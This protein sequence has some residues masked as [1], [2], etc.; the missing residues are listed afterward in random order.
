MMQKPESHTHTDTFIPSPVGRFWL[1]P[2][3]RRHVPVRN[4]V[5]VCRFDRTTAQ[6]PVLEV[7]VHPPQS[8]P[9]ARSALAKLWPVAV[10]AIFVGWTAHD[11]LPRRAAEVPEDAS[12]AVGVGPAATPG[13][14]GIGVVQAPD[15]ATQ[16]IDAQ[17]PSLPPSADPA[18]IVRD[19][20][21]RQA[22]ASVSRGGGDQYEPRA[23]DEEAARRQQET[24][25][26]ARA[27]RLIGLLRTA[28][29]GYRLQVCS[30]A[31]GGIAVSTTRDHTGPYISARAEA[32]ALEEGARLAGVS[33]G[34]VRIPWGEFPEPEDP[35]NG[36]HPAAVAE[37]WG[38]GN[39]TGWGH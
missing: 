2:E 22:T 31:R 13:H 30:E 23:R 35:A 37:R 14:G 21:P 8:P 26:R 17:R 20:A 6:V 9:P 5:C 7:G 36:Y 24:E 27:S 32:Q 10:I 12:P 16:A 28:H 18:T 34:W 39:V 15:D 11:R 3:C 19:E 33:P 1:C 29:A 25:W 38:C 4:D